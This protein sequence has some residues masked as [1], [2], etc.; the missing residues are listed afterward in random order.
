MKIR[1]IETQDRANENK[2]IKKND[3]G[4]MPSTFVFA[5]LGPE[6]WRAETPDG[7]TVPLHWIKGEVFLE[8]GELEEAGFVAPG[9][10]YANGK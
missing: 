3:C 2:R 10:T 6:G 4:E 5:E 1:R 9:R 8:R 7:T